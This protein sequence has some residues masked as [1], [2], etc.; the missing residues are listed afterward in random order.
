[1]LLFGYCRDFSLQMGK[2]T[3]NEYIF[4]YTWI[5]W[6]SILCRNSFQLVDQKEDKGRGGRIETRDR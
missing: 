2:N 6:R 4:D 3:Q 5:K 1:M